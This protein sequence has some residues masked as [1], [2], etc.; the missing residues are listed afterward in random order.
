[1]ARM[2]ARRKISKDKGGAKPPITLS[3][4]AIPSPEHSRQK[5]AVVGI[6]ASAG[7]LEA[8][9]EFFAHTPRDTG[10]AF[11]VMTHQHPGHVSLLP[12]LLKK[13]TR[14]PVCEATDSVRV[15]PNHIYVA[16]PD[17]YLAIVSG[18]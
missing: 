10:M 2:R 12:E 11:V 3:K 5:F 18:K 8:L 6:G 13:F 1:M 14:L 7:G 16:T 4:D 9:Q 15:Q 17:G